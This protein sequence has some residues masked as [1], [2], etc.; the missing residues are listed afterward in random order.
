MFVLLIFFL[1]VNKIFSSFIVLP[2]KKESIK[3]N[4]PQSKYNINIYT[5]LEIGEPKQNIKIYFRDDFFSFFILS[6]ESTYNEEELKNPFESNLKDLKIIDTFYD[7]K[8][9]STYNNFSDNQNFFIDIFYR[10][11]FLSSETFYFN[12]DNQN[13]FKRFND[14]EF[15]LVNKIK[16]NRT[17]I[18]G[19]IGLLV[20]E[21]FLEGAQSFAKMLVKKNITTYYL[22]S[23]IYTNENE[24][25]FLFGDFPHVLYKDKFLREQ[26]IETD[27]KL[28]VYKQKWN[29][30]FN[31]IFI[32]IKK[33]GIDISNNDEYK[34]LY[35]NITL[36][37]ELKHNL[38]LIIG[39]VEYQQLIDN[40]FFNE[41]IK[42]GICHKNNAL[43]NDF[44]DDNINYTYYYCNN[45]KS[46]N[47]TKFPTLFL[48]QSKLEYTFELNENDLFI[49][50][51]EKWYFMIIFEGEEIQ[52]QRHKW[53]FGEPLLKKYQFVFD[54]TNYKIGFYNPIISINSSERKDKEY[55]KININNYKELIFFAFLALF[56]FIILLFLYHKLLVKKDL[57]DSGKNQY[58]ELQNLT[59]KKI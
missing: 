2:F 42:N 21:Y 47:K 10:K 4:F 49:L 51:N 58:T 29:L 14:I 20:D 31:E 22:W 43:I 5:N 46:F 19:A 6:R 8:E 52:D 38:G 34:Y 26:Y 44:N 30:D 50:S 33:D 24:G 9:S 48:K 13:D 39:T 27:I 36:Y 28:N 25:I 18:S 41:N 35:L 16:P 53:M 1:Y 59:I 12:V 7:N 32:K 45:D 56:I 55:D 37:G 40:L 17:F 54:P 3:N 11:G 15:V 23:K 57:N